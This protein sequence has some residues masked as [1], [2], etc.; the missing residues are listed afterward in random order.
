MSAF[1]LAAALALLTS[2]AGAQ[3]RR[4]TPRDTI[5]VPARQKAGVLSNIPGPEC[6][7]MQFSISGTFGIFPGQDSTGFDARYMYSDPP[8]WNAPTPLANPP[9]WNGTNYQVYLQVSNNYTFADADSLHV[10]E[11]GYQPSHTY[12]ALDTGIGG[13]Y[14]F[15]IFD[16]I[17]EDST[18]SD[19]YWATG[20]VTVRLAQYTAGISVQH[21]SLQFPMTPVGMSSTLIDSIASYGIDPL[22]VD[23][24]WIGGPRPYEFAFSTQPQTSAPFTLS[25]ESANKFT[26]SYFP[27]QPDSVSVDT[28]YLRCSNAECDQRLIAIVLT[29]TGGAPKGSIGPDT[30]DFGTV[31][32]NF[33][34]SAYANG[35]N[36]GTAPWIIDN[37]SI[38]PAADQAFFSWNLSLPY[39]VP[40]GNRVSIKFTFIP[41]AA[42]PYLATAIISTHDG[43]QTPIVLRGNGAI[44]IFTVLNS[45][46]TFDTVL[47]NSTKIR[48]DTVRNDGQWPARVTRVSIVGPG[49]Q[50]YS[51]QDAADS[52]GFI[53]DPGQARYY[54]ISYHPNL[55][56]DDPEPAVLEFDFDDHSQPKTITL[57]GWEKRPRI[58]YDTNSINFGNVKV[59]TQSERSLGV[60]NAS[61]SPAP[62]TA[63]FIPFNGWFALGPSNNSFTTGANS[64][65]I[66][67]TPPYHGLFSDWLYLSCNGQY[68]SVYLYGF[69]V[70]PH[71]VFNP[72]SL[73]F[74]I[75]QDFKNYV[76]GT[77]L[78]DTGDY[79][80]SICALKIVGPDASEF[81][82][83]PL[84]QTPSSGSVVS[85]PDTLRAGRRDTLYFPVNFTTHALA[86]RDHYAT[87]EVLYCDGTMDTI[88][89]HAKEEDEF[90]Q[91][92]SSKVDF[93]KV[94]VGTRKD[95]TTCFFNSGT[96]T[97]PLDSIWILNAGLPF[98]LMH[99][100]GTVPSNGI[101]L[102][103]TVFAPVTRGT[104][105]GRIHGSGGGMKADSIVIT[106]IG[107]QSMPVLSTKQLDLGMESLTDTSIPQLLSLQDTGDWPLIAHIEK[108]DDPYNEFS[109]QI[110]G[111]SVFVNPV[112]FDT[113]A[114]GGTAY[115]SI[116][117]T[118]RHP[119]LPDHESRL[120]FNYD[121]GTVD[122]VLLIGRDTSNFLSFDRDTIDF[123]KVRL[124]T[125][126]LT[127]PLALVNTSSADLTALT[128]KEPA[129]PFS[130]SPLAPITVKSQNTA[131]LEVTFNPLTIGNF[132][133]S[134]SGEGAPFKSS[135][136]DSVFL[137][138]SAAAPM[139]K[140]SVDTLDFDT[141]ALGHSVTKSFTLSN[142][143]N[144]PLVIS[145][146]PV[147]GPNAPDFMPI[148]IA[149]DT[150]INDS[151]QTVYSISFTGS[152]PL[153]RTPRLG[154]LTWTL[155]DGST[156][157][158]VLRAYDEPPYRVQIGFPHA[159]WG[160]PGD[161][162]A[163]ELDLQS[164]IPDTLGIQHIEG[165]VTW[166][167]SIV[168]MPPSGGPTAGNIVPASHWQTRIIYP[169][170]SNGGVFNYDISSTTDTLSKTGTLLN[171][172]LKLNSDL[173]DGASSPLIGY[174]T[175]PD[176]YE[177][178]ATEAQ[179][180]IFL[181]SNCGTIHLI[182]GGLP[183]AS[184]I[185]QNTPNPFGA[186]GSATTALPFDIGTD[187]T[188][189]TIR[190]LDPTGRE[191]LRPVDHQS[192][193]RGRYS[194]TID[195]STLAAGIY[196]YEFQSG[197][198]EP[199]MGK[200]VVE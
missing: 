149:T 98:S 25:N 78:I 68:D 132:R 31:R 7:Q 90:I 54:T 44:P 189:V 117:F 151:E 176:T 81:S 114:I 80:L 84:V 70:E 48:Y 4:A 46:L 126:A 39:S 86:G 3:W 179:S 55:G 1:A 92:C 72:P 137:L 136:G 131:L 21:Q 164:S 192:F 198:G 13:K 16:R 162:I 123:G 94:R 12:T 19:Y 177:A 108:I 153:Q 195:A 69:G 154:L 168:T 67:F 191:V 171:F 18:G 147:T 199:Q 130:A 85:L 165:T 22:V 112:A 160:R 140:L 159:Y 58:T 97:L 148:A 75:C 71:P 169:M 66:V 138:G 121:D 26:I 124:G 186:S 35:Y 197:G 11:T 61:G 27:S 119:E 106:G 49:K 103:T 52:N 193:A 163:A 96:A 91:F 60:H 53:L 88:P 194:V 23:S 173:T 17:H 152:T 9:S 127:L 100:S 37:I 6:T 113:L 129:N 134:I 120:V 57:A 184:F 30:L 77:T 172:M 182:T 118:P 150:T 56:A 190:M 50:F 74:G 33:S 73:D 170:G 135:N 141:V 110:V 38:T 42:I 188:I 107:A 63:M 196:F 155:D 15:R 14:E 83:L 87:L 79:P 133:S 144:W 143:G 93:G 180:S 89:L 62:F 166:D 36:A 142:L 181:D 157:Q 156:F 183:I 158:L 20:G 102:D 200:M 101:F 8:G 139:P 125:P 99:G 122:T 175:L 187:N 51:F 64:L 185:R 65:P 128:L 116:T 28:L 105:T 32:V 146:T 115:Y 76:Q 41:A 40:P 145:R 167:P 34:G 111:T 10:R 29:G 59:N 43:K 104:F 82:L 47:T 109:V 5:Y 161:K 45:A 178:I 24:I 2:S 95:T 174:D